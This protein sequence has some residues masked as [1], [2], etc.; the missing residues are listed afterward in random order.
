ML[1]PIGILSFML[2]IGACLNAQ[3]PPRIDS[4]HV[5]KRIPPGTHTS[6]S[7]NALAWRLHQQNAS[8]RT[9]SGGDIQVVADAFAEYKPTRH[10]SGAITGLSHV[11]MVFTGGRPVAFGVTED[12]D[13]VI[14][15]TARREYHI[16]TVGEH[17]RVRALLAQ[18]MVEH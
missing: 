1:K 17:V 3:S 4:V 16:S 9:L 12:L 11:A 8:H 10:T 14:N 18:L 2:G 6:A 15:F 7:A 13:R 5:Y